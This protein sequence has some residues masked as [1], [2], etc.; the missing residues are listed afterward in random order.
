[1]K[2]NS[3]TAINALHTEL[4]AEIWKVDSPLLRRLVRH[5]VRHLVRADRSS[6]AFLL[7]LDTLVE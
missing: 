6:L 4:I 5:F 3:I 7:F 1:M 2:L